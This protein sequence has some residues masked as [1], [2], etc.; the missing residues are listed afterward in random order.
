MR[1]FVK[2]TKTFFHC[3]Q[4]GCEA[5]QRLDTAKDKTGLACN[6]CLKGKPAARDIGGNA[7]FPCVTCGRLFRKE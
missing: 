7:L 3:Q 6:K 2:G 1:K 4:D 5:A